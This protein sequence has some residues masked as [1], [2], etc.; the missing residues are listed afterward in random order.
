MSIPTAVLPIE[1]IMATLSPQFTI[2]CIMATLEPVDITSATRFEMAEA[3]SR[4]RVA[5]DQYRNPPSHDD[6]STT[7]Q[8]YAK[9]VARY[10]S[11]EI[12]CNVL[13]SEITS[14]AAEIAR[15]RAQA[16]SG[17]K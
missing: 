14:M 17:G 9:A 11:A 3:I 8:P 5:I 16:L 2:D 1:L 10:E 15:L 7:I 6:G 4:S 12:R 13:E